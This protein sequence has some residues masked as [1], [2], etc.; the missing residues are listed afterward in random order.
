MKINV[1]S[2]SV[3]LLLYEAKVLKEETLNVAGHQ[4]KALINQASGV[5]VVF[6]HGFS[7][8][9]D[10]WQRIS[11]TEML[12]KKNVPFLAL[13]MPYGQKSECKPKTHN[14]EENTVVAKEGIKRVFGAEVPVVV[15]A[16]LGG[17]IALRYAMKFPVKGLLLIAPSGALAN[18][19]LQAYNKWVF[20]V[21]IIWGSEDHIISGED[22]RTLAGKLSNGKLVTYEGAGHSAYK[23]E[24]ERFKLDLLELYAAAVLT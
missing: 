16:S 15:G 22:M 8:T 4:C 11:V 24:P 10:I 12:I 3:F 21:R 6:L 7:Y 9:S 20:G 1:I 18:D 17:N 14:Q 2:R 23:D 13:D 5:P 19:L